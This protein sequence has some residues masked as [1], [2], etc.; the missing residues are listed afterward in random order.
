[1][2]VRLVPPQQTMAPTIQTQAGAVPRDLVGS[3]GTPSDQQAR[4]PAVS[5][6]SPARHAAGLV[7]GASPGSVCVQRGG[8]IGY[9]G[10]IVAQSGGVATVQPHVGASKHTDVARSAVG[11]DSVGVTRARDASSRPPARRAVHPSPCKE[12]GAFCHPGW[13]RR[14]GIKVERAN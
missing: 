6:R 7:T 8:Y 12:T 11:M 14:R 5:V 4:R 10:Y 13:G 2:V 3:L 1:M 9:I